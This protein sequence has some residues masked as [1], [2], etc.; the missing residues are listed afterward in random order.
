MRVDA[1]HRGAFTLIETVT[2]LSIAG[3]LM[4]ALGS[5]MSMSLRAMP[6]PEEDVAAVAA[7][8][9][10]AAAWLGDDLSAAVSVVS[11][12]STA[13]EFRVADRDKDGVEEVI[14]YEWTGGG[15]SLTRTVNGGA[16]AAVGPALSAFV[17]EPNWRSV[18][19]PAAGVPTLGAEEAILRYPGASNATQ[20]LSGGAVAMTFT[21]VLDA[22]ATSWRVT[23]C[24]MLANVS[25][26]TVSTMRARLY[27]GRVTNLASQTPLA[28]SGSIGLN[29]LGSAMPV[30]FTF[31]SAPDLPPGTQVSIVVDAT[32]TLG[33]VQLQYTT[34][35][36]A[37]GTLHA[38]VGKDGSW[39]TYTDGGAPLVI[40]GRQW[41]PAV[42]NPSESRLMSVGI[43][44][45]PVQAKALP[46]RLTVATLAEPVTK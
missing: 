17:A 46:A 8:L 2:A 33:E 43:A 12:T 20:S 22:D 21:P 28:T 25:I 38:T 18:S 10:D 26:L 31:A 29:V 30:T 34:S 13:L 41:K 15:Q 4:V 27:A 35:G 7:E 45:T 6:R 32:I 5:M 40:N 16:A 24:R 39:T 42:T 19:N 37:M 1:V 36:V 14:R 3:I 23:S 11:M 9:Q 44:M